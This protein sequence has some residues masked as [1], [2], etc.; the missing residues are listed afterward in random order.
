MCTA[1]SSPD[2]NTTTIAVV[3]YDLDKDL[4]SELQAEVRMCACVR[5]LQRIGA[6][7]LYQ[8]PRCTCMYV[9]T[10][11]SGDKYVDIKM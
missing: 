3:R 2:A 6:H 1:L 5:E 9:C 7:T 4:R 10:I 11:C 8:A